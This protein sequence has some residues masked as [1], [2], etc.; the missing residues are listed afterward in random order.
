MSATAPTRRA[1]VVYE[2][3]F[4]NTAAIAAAVADGL[5]GEGM[6]VV[7]ADVTEVAHLD[8]A[9]DLLVVGAPTHAF[10]L[11][12]PST[13]AQAVT[14]GAEQAHAAIGLREWLATLPPGGAA[15]VAIFDTRVAKVRGLP[16]GAA[17][18]AARLA[19]RR[20]FVLVGKPARFI[21][22]GTEG[23]LADGETE[24]ASEWGRALAARQRSDSRA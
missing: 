24:R 13:R 20:G 14:Q 2:S 12:R 4:G 8:L 1:A 19:R 15:R 3:M 22:S 5:R 16:V 6:D 9:V 11:S 18:S 7:A 10:G 17:Q 21:V 23:P